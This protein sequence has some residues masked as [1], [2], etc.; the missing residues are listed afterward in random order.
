MYFL[1][2]HS[3]EFYS[4]RASLERNYFREKERRESNPYIV[5]IVKSANFG[6]DLVVWKE[7]TKKEIFA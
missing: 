2:M 1:L 5:E 7:S 4:A 6:K 3:A